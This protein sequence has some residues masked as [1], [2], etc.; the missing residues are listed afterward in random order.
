MF[1]IIVSPLNSSATNALPVLSGD[2]VT[3]RL[4]EICVPG[5]IRLVNGSDPS[6][7]RVEVCVRRSFATVCQ[8]YQWTLREAVTVCRQLGF[9]GSGEIQHVNKSN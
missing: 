8:I 2:V 1:F 7:G 5:D 3:V 9:S 6:Q 4:S